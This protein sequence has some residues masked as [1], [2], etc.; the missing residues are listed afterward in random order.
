MAHKI[1]FSLGKQIYHQ[2]RPLQFCP[3][4]LAFR[5]PVTTHLQ[6]KEQHCKIDTKTKLLMQRDGTG[7]EEAAE[8]Q[9][10]R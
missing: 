6:R 3:Q 10:F 1:G 5:C 9:H 4:V 7:G 8:C 2:T